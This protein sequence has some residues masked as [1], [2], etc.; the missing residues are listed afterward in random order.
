MADRG[1]GVR[2]LIVEDDPDTQANLQS[3]L[4]LDG[5]QTESAGSVEEMSGKARAKKRHP[6]THLTRPIASVLRERVVMADTLERA[7]HILRE[8]LIP[9]S[10]FDRF[11][12]EEDGVPDQ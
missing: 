8:Y 6:V 3:I 12:R 2:V 7:H 10:R 4:E 1:N 9:A 11:R 5:Y